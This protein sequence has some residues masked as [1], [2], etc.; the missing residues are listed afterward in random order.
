[1]Q[2]QK[3][4]YIFAL[5]SVMFWSTMSTAFKLTLSYLAYDLLLFWSVWFAVIVLGIM[6]LIQRKTSYLGQTSSVEF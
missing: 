4:A 1:M 2:D 6:V 3:K 5:L